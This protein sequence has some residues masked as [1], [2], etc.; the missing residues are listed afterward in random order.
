MA[1][2]V[3]NASDDR[4]FGIVQTMEEPMTITAEMKQAAERAGSVPVRL[5]DPETDDAYYLVR[6][7]VFERFKAVLDDG[8]DMREVG[9]LIDDAMRD[10]DACDP[11]LDSYQKYRR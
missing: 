3:V 7:E 6:E 8:L 1:W 4:Q 11:L 9:I 10:D 5:T 2:E